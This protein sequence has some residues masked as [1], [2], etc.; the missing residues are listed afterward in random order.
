M[1]KYAE[2]TS[3]A[4]DRSRSEIEKTLNKYG[5][6]DTRIGV[7]QSKGLAVVEFELKGRLVKIELPLPSLQDFRLTP[8]GQWRHGSTQQTAYEQGVRQR[9]RALLLVIKAKLEAVESGITTFD[10]EFLAHTL[11]PNGDTVGEWIAPQ[12]DESY[13][14]TLMPP[15]LLALGRGE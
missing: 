12:L 6:I 13:R 8:T 4:T 7:Y 3:V 9:L 10:A 11:L 1:T 14:T 15:S 2:N 5:A